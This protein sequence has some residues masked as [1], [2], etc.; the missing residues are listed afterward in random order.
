MLTKKDHELLKEKGITPEQIQNQINQLTNGFPNLEI[1]KPA[2]RKDGIKHLTEKQQAEMVRI[3]EKAPR[4]LKRV[5]FVPASGAATRMFKK[6]YEVYHN[7]EGTEE[8][9]LQIMSDKGFDSLYYI[10]HNLSSFAFYNDLR[11]SFEKSGNSLETV[12]KNKDFKLLLGT[13]LTE[14]GLNYG[15]LPKGLLKFHKTFSG[16][17][18][19]MEEHFLEGI[20]YAASGKK[21]NL[22]F[23]ISPDHQEMFAE[24]AAELIKKYEKE[25]KAKFEVS[26]SVQKPATDTVAV[27]M[28]NKPFRNSNGDLVFR[29]G[30]HGALIHNLNEIDAD[31][32]FIKNIDNVVQDRLKEKTNFYKMVLAG[33]LL[34]VKT[35]AAENF[36]KL[37]KKIKKETLDEV[38]IFVQKKLYVKMP[39]DF[40]DWETDKKV[41]FLKET[42]DRPIRVCGM[43]RNEGE[44]GGGPYWVKNE[45]GTQSLQIVE[46][47]QFTDEQKSIMGKATHFNPVDIVCST[48]N[49]KGDKYNLLDFVDYNT[50]FISVKS[51]EGKDLKAL[52]MP[53]LWN[54][55]MA[56]WNTIFIEV[57]IET[58]NPVK[59]IND[60]LRAEHM[61]EKDLLAVDENERTVID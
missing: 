37:K 42:I 49:F 16:E 6:L 54:G 1:I 25:Y 21:V 55:A 59:T 8:D 13:L 19:P 18:T 15:N 10:C 45:N 36:K 53:G 56:K 29:P 57:P 43:V 41:A 5:K 22:H 17:R 39:N 32:I 14:K 30:G 20:H 12:S 46:S 2:T 24:H 61:F 52:E 51:M 3:Y 40:S 50:G 28:N 34:N 9:Y 58:F 27:D 26:F 31:I 7:Y 48:K 35:E 33:V 47:S 23:T 44:P 4:R 11:D 60:L 38:E